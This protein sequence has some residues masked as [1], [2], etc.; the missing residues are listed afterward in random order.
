MWSMQKNSFTVVR[1]AL[2]AGILLAGAACS[3]SI[4]ETPSE[5]AQELIEGDLATQLGLELS[6]AECDGPASA[7]EGA[8]FGC[9]ATTGDGD[10]VKFVVEY[11]SEDDYFAYA[12]NVV[13]TDDLA[14]IEQDAAAV[15]GPEVGVTIDPADISCP[16]ETTVLVGDELFC[17]IT[18]PVRNER[19]E[20]IATFGTYV[21][22]QG[23][24]SVFYE[25][26]AQIN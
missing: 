21:R 1:P 11:D 25:I 5:A 6:D 20:M 13:V 16:E 14:T 17:E 10:T 4:G 24:E 19:F 3:F 15:L 26:G 23:Y 8:E 7:D 12:T 9:T 22:E 18:D 2:L